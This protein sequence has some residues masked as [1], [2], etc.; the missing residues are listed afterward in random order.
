MLE[1]S[2][3]DGLSLDVNFQNKFP[4]VILLAE[5]HSDKALMGQRWAS[6][7]GNGYR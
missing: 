2:S 7:S 5:I 6:S 4:D 3:L 1:C